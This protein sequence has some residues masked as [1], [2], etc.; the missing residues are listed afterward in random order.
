V[1]VAAVRVVLATRDRGPLGARA[2]ARV[3]EQLS[4]QPV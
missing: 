4:A 2:D 1:L 3:P